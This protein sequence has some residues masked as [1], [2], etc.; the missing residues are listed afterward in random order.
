M[1]E[2][3]YVRSLQ[4]LL[5]SEAGEGGEGIDASGWRELDR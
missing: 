2:L 3:Q 5:L 1:G 4:Y